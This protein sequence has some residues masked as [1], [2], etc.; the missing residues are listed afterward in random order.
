[1]KTETI[2]KAH[3]IE[4]DVEFEVVDPSVD[5]LIDAQMAEV[6]LEMSVEH[7]DSK[8][9]KA[10]A[11]SLK[12]LAEAHK[13]YSQ[14]VAE[15]EKATVEKKS[16]DKQMKLKLVE[17]TPRAVGIVI[18]GALTLG[19]FLVEQQHPVANRMINRINDFITRP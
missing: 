2:L 14:G 9:Y 8:S 12:L 5:H 10:S 4:N 7:S 19:W 6:L 3:G 13:A 16:L 1:M 18:S 11:E 17:V 15:R